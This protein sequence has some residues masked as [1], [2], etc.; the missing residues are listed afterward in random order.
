MR[1]LRP[2]R[3]G[4]LVEPAARAHDDGVLRTP[5]RALPAG[6]DERPGDR[7][8]AQKG[9]AG[10]KHAPSHRP[11]ECAI[12]ARSAGS[13]PAK[14]S[15]EL[16]GA[17]TSGVMREPRVA[18]RVLVVLR[19]NRHRHRDGEARQGHDRSL[20]V[21]VEAA[22]HRLA[23][24]DRARLEIDLGREVARRREREPPEE[25][26]QPARPVER[27]APQG[28]EERVVARVVAAAVVS[29]V[30]HHALDATPRGTLPERVDERRRGPWTALYWTKSVCE[31]GR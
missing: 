26:V 18:G 22:A 8:Q 19:R 30:D 4:H 5:F 10:E 23:R 13:R 29:E 7:E 11:R 1:L 21:L 27:R 6:G 16:S 28:G 17:A 14:K 24:E 12:A 3:H 25:D 2:R 31:L 15:A 9:D 20:A